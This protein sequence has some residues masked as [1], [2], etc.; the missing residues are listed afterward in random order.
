ML[1]LTFTV[2]QEKFGELKEVELVENGAN[3]LV[4][5][6]NKKKYVE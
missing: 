4:T 3:I 1:D 6:D 5:E 2:T